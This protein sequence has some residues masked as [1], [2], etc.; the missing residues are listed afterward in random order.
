MQAVVQY[1]YNPSTW[2]SEADG[3]L[4]SRSSWSAEQIL[5][6]PGLSRET[7]SQKTK[8]NQAKPNQ[9]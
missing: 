5:G 9:T 1:A 4:S 2:E 3:S 8:P 7:L 6:Q